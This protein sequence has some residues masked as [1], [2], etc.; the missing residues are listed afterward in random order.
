M[1][2]AAT[3]EQPLLAVQVSQVIFWQSKCAAQRY[4][5]ISCVVGWAAVTQSMLL[6]VR[7]KNCQVMLHCVF[8]FSCRHSV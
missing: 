7:H 2:S 6:L 4:A 5:M 3:T 8:L 1:F